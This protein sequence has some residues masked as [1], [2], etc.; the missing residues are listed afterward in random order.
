MQVGT[1]QRGWGVV[2][3][4]A[5]PQAPATLRGQEL[6]LLREWVGRGQRARPHEKRSRPGEVGRPRGTHVTGSP[7]KLV[8]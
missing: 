7:Q 1:S 6:R 3:E 8:F 5:P 2:G 4:E